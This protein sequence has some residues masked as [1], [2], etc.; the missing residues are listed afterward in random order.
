MTS[1]YRW[2][3]ES[4][5]LLKDLYT[6]GASRKAMASRFGLSSATVLKKAKQLGLT[7]PNAWSD[8]KTGKLTELYREGLSASQIAA[9]L[10]GTS[11][12]AVIGK[13]HRIGLVGGGT[14]KRKTV[15]KTDPSGVKRPRPQTESTSRSQTIKQL[16]K[17]EALPTPK[18]EDVA[19]VSL[20]DLE[21]HHCRWPAGD[22]VQGFCGCQKVPGLP[23][24]EGHA[25]RAY[26]TETAR[27][28]S[29]EVKRPLVLVAS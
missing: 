19:R 18:S 29:T 15:R 27:R 24:C 25:K 17:T 20:L 13:L 3:D 14:A 2:T 5:Q 4:I 12:S 11:R 8:E 9:Q 1:P 28:P 22:P 26:R 7:D 23:Y 6:K 10:G 16:L 21:P